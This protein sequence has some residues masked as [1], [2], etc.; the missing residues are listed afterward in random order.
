MESDNILMAAS[1]K[2]KNIP[3]PLLAVSWARMCEDLSQHDAQQ[4][5]NFLRGVWKIVSQQLPESTD[6]NGMTQAS[7]LFL[8]AYFFD[9]G[10]WSKMC[11]EI[12][13]PI[14]KAGIISQETFDRFTE[15][16]LEEY[17]RVHRR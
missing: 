2:V 17:R 1:D 14:A 5:E 11:K 13:G 12:S 3:A 8:E 7:I 9:S 15:K 6:R 4:L 16:T 10:N